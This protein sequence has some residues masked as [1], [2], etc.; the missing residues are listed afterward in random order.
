MPEMNSIINNINM[1][2]PV[3]RGYPFSKLRYNLTLEVLM[4]IDYSDTLSFMFRAN[5]ESRTFLI[6]K[7]AMIRNGFENEGLNIY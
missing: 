2:E 4:N 7:L 1:V 6:N 5:K 3:K